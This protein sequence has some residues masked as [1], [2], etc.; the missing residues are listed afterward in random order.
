MGGDGI[1]FNLNPVRR[2]ANLL[3][4]FFITNIMQRTI[5]PIFVMCI[6]K[7]KKRV[8]VRV[9]VGHHNANKRGREGEREKMRKS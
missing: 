1:L 2:I 4:F 7:R 5:V 9:Q 8:M 3:F 6:K